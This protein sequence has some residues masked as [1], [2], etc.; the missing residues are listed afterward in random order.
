MKRIFDFII[1][2]IASLLLLPLMLLV[3][4]LVKITS[5]GPVL[6]WSKRVGRYG[7]YFWMP[8]FRSMLVDTPNVASHLLKDHLMY[9]TPIGATLRKLSLDEM[10]QLW[11]I[12]IG[13]MSFVGPRPALFNQIDLIKLR[14]EFA[15]NNLKPGLTGLAQINGRDDLSLIEKVNFDR[16]YFNKQSMYF[17]IKIMLMTFIKVMLCKNVSH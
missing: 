8:K 15:I 10:P 2:F 13:D 6:Y 3:A 1:A 7:K 17:D 4:F 16:E 12:L 14:E 11:S 5:P 9:L